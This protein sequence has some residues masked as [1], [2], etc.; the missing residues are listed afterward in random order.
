MA[1][2]PSHRKIEIR[3]RLLAAATLLAPLVAF[4]AVLAGRF[5]WLSLELAREIVGVGVVRALVFLGLAAA[6]ACVLAAWPDPRR[7]GLHALAALVVAGGSAGVFFIQAD[8]VRPGAGDVT[9]DPAEP[10]TPSRILAAERARDGAVPLGS[11]ASCEGLAA[12]PTQVAPETA[13]W[14][15]EQAGFTVL[16]AAAFR[17]EG[18]RQGYWFGLGHDAVVR[19]RPGRTDIR[20][21]AREDQP[22]GDAACRLARRIAAAM[23]PDQAAR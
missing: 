4:L 23:A 9:T 18:V 10:P 8:K 5:G 6:L 21:A 20:V 3:L 7:R 22:Q 2:D 15:L 16:G 11:S 14:A 19:I 1:P 12:L 13:A 17:A